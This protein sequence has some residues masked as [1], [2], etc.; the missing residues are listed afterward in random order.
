MRLLI[1]L[2]FSFYVTGGFAQTVNG[3]EEAF[4]MT[5]QG[6]SIRGFVE[7]GPSYGSKIGFK[8]EGGD[9][10]TF[11]S[12]KEIKFIL[13]PNRYLEN[14]DLGKRELLMTL[15]VEGKARLFSQ[16][17]SQVVVPHSTASHY[18]ARANPYE[19]HVP[20]FVLK[21][22]AAYTEVKK[23]RYQETLSALLFDCPEVVEKLRH[24]AFTYEDMGS[25]V[26]Y[27]NSCK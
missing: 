10:Q 7:V 2:I 15:V 18:E 25:A 13:T 16:V 9:A 8:K 6:D 20:L 26:A 17:L 3:F 1:F 23:K 19:T 22:G 12:T 24:N 27:Y 21:K 11:L 14:I 4:I 5:K